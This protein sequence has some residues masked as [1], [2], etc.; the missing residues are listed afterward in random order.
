MLL[1]SFPNKLPLA[2][3]RIVDISWWEDASI[4]FGIGIAVGQFWT[5]W[6]WANGFKCGA[7]LRFNIGWA[8]MVVVELGL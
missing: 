5:I 2:Q 6:T 1:Q 7:G 8:K 3:A 4:S